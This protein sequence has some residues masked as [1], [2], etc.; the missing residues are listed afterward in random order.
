MA[1]STR[2]ATLLSEYL[3]S[4]DMKAEHGKQGHR[5]LRRKLKLYLW[6][7]GKLAQEERARKRDA[8]GPAPQNKHKA[9]DGESMSEALKRKDKQ[10]AERNANRRR[11][12]GGAPTPVASTSRVKVE[13]GVQAESEMLRE[14]E[15]IADL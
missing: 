5:L 9:K 11:M 1:G 10:I 7:K 3:D 4:R 13:E 15:D 14:A 12:R 6:W 8:A 2:T